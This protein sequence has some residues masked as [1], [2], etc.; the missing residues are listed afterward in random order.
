M[1]V[2]INNPNW[3]SVRQTGAADKAPAP[4]TH[5]PAQKPAQADDQAQLVAFVSNLTRADAAEVIAL[6]QRD[7]TQQSYQT[8]ASAYAEFD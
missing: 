4:P 3:T 6:T 8:V 1:L 2:S 5:T 7:S